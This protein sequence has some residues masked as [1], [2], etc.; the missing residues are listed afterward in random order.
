MNWIA[1][2]KLS[3]VIE[4]KKRT[5]TPNA[6]QRA[7][8]HKKKTGNNYSTRRFQCSHGNLKK[9]A[10]YNLEEKTAKIQEERRREKKKGRDS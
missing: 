9:S 6:T 2:P 7:Q 3:T 5:E 4:E 1:N 8:I 10:L